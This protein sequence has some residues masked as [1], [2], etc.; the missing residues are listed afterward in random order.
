[1][2]RFKAYAAKNEEWETFGQYLQNA[3][4]LVAKRASEAAVLPTPKDYATDLQ[5]F[6]R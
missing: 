1:L 4:L 6:N 5:A 3:A 2:T